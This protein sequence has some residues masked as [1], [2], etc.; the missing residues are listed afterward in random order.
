MRRLILLWC[1][2]TS[3]SAVSQQVV[4]TPPSPTTVYR[5]ATATNTTNHITQ[6]VFSLEVA[7]GIATIHTAGALA[8]GTNGP[9]NGLTV[10][11]LSPLDASNPYVI[12]TAQNNNL[13]WYSY[14]YTFDSKSLTASYQSY[15][16][17]FPQMVKRSGVLHVFFREGVAHANDPT[18]RIMWMTSNGDTWSTP[19]VLFDDTSSDCSGTT[20]D[21]RLG[22]V[23]LAGNNNIILWYRK[24]DYQTGASDTYYTYYDGTWATPILFRT[25]PSGPD[26]PWCITYGRVFEYDTRM[27]TPISSCGG[28]GT[29]N[30]LVF[31]TDNGATWTAGFKHVTALG[32]ETMPTEEASYYWAGG[33][34][35]VG[36]TRALSYTGAACGAIA[37]GPLLFQYSTDGGDTWTITPSNLSFEAL[38][39]GY[40]SATFCKSFP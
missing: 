31:S 34:T 7:D 9:G 16:D 37:C 27:V 30:Y 10:S 19:V 11:G 15:H 8:A 40:R 20:C 2:A 18:G 36:V 17:A 39:P 25:Q 26:A 24:Y 28:G 23:G 5:Q 33:T 21:L 14:A 13:G 38:P 4:F 6:Q 1:L 22:A 29:Q 12:L 35:I 3:L 32:Y